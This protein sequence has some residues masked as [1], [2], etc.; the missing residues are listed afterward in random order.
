MALKILMVSRFNSDFERW[1][2][3]ADYLQDKIDVHMLHAWDLER[4][5]NPPMFAFLKSLDIKI[6]Q[7]SDLSFAHRIFLIINGLARWFSSKLLWKIGQ[8]FRRMGKVTM[9]KNIDNY[10]K[11]LDPDIL[12]I[13]DFSEQPDTIYEPL[14]YVYTWF[15]ANNRWIMGCAHASKIYFS[16]NDRVL[17]NEHINMFFSTSDEQSSRLEGGSLI[18]PVMNVGDLRNSI[19]FLN[20][21]KPFLKKACDSRTV[22]LFVGEKTNTDHEYSEFIIQL[23]QIL[24]NDKDLDNLIVKLH[25]NSDWYQFSLKL[26]EHPKVSIISTQFNSL[27]VCASAEVIITHQSSI[28]F[29]ALAYK[30]K[31]YLIDYLD[32]PGKHLYRDLE[33]PSFNFKQWLELENIMNLP[34]SFN[35]EAY[36]KLAFNNADDGEN[37]ELVHQFL[38]NHCQNPPV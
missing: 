14:K 11:D 19:H 1:V 25:P 36:K 26:G 24:S 33:L 6:M 7:Y 30:K 4:L 13:T 38:M 18:H 8:F 21:L 34:F 9:K 5:E 12:F 2:S 3:L 37:R 31:L 35:T 23:I 20:R 15:N 29:D 27:E 22:A 28:I 16:P 17:I 10:L 32:G